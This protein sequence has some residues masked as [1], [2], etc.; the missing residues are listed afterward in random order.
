MSS[1]QQ[2]LE[3]ELN[4]AVD[5]LV[6]AEGKAS[7]FAITPAAPRSGGEDRAVSPVPKA[8][9]ANATKPASRRRA[10]STKPAIAALAT[11]DEPDLDRSQA[12]VYVKSTYV[13][14]KAQDDKLRRLA[15]RQKLALDETMRLALQA[16][17][18]ITG[19]D[20]D[21]T[22][23]TTS[24]IDN[25]GKSELGMPHA[26]LRLWP[27]QVEILRQCRLL[28]GVEASEIMRRAIDSYYAQIGHV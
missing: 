13:L 22:Q 20:Q 4:S 8:A 16:Y 27:Q 1:V 5:T 11:A 9:P 18:E 6:P 19:L 28:F 25:P 10:P 23:L 21:L 15:V 3:K 2:Q 17:I 12:A 26:S 14:G 7:L 24:P